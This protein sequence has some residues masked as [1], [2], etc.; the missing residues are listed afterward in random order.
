MV[1]TSK[2]T[3]HEFHSITSEATLHQTLLYIRS[4]IEKSVKDVKLNKYSS[5]N[6]WIRMRMNNNYNSTIYFSG[7]AS[8]FSSKTSLNYSPS[9]WIILINV[10]PLLLAIYLKLEKAMKQIQMK[11]SKTLMDEALEREDSTQE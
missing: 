6:Y 10:S 3:K 8:L 2:Q 4:Y 9:L 7:K 5:N 1:K 11:G